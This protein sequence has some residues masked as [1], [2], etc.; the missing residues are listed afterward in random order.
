MTFTSRY[1]DVHVVVICGQSSHKH[2]SKGMTLIVIPEV[3]G[4]LTT[5]PTADGTVLYFV[6]L[7]KFEV[8]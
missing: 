6:Q 1:C 7:W 3:L 5:L 2:N 4:D 8:I